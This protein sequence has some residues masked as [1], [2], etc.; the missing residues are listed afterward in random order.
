MKAF[1]SDRYGGPEVLRLE[2][3]AKPTAGDGDVLVKIHAISVNPADWHLLRGSPV[4]MRAAMGLFRPKAKIIGADVAGTVEAIG[5]GVTRLKPGDEVIGDLSAGRFG[6]FAEYVAD[7]ESMF[8]AKPKNLSFQESAAIPLAGI[9]A[10]QGVMKRGPIRA[11]QTVL[12]NGASG[13]VGHFAVQIAK[14]FGAEV[15]GVTSTKNIDRVR[16]LGADHVID[17]TKEDFTLG[18]KSWDLVVETVGNKSLGEIRRALT[19]NGKATV[20]GFESMPRVL[21]VS[22]FGGKSVSMMTAKATMPDL[23]TLAKLAEADSLKPTIDKTYPFSELPAA[24][25]YLEEGHVA[26]KVVVE[27]G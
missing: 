18:G 4:L 9:T 24:I 25:A 13:G 22:L 5:E 23:E 16:S 21:A 6:A 14:S 15:T 10:L 2:E 19:P 1:V 3:V 26:G 8:V 27:I 11:G 7:K 20:I 17:Y 12:I